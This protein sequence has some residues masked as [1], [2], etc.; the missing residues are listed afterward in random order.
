MNI[1]LDSPY[2]TWPISQ[3]HHSSWQKRMCGKEKN[4]EQGVC[5]G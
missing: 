1:P 3:A 2:R 4:R 5:R